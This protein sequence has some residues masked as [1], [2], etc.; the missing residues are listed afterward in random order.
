[1][2]VESSSAWILV[3]KKAIS[4]C[5]CTKRESLIWSFWISTQHE[6]LAVNNAV[7]HT[8]K[9]IVALRRCFAAD[10]YNHH[11]HD[12]LIFQREQRKKKQ[13]EP[14]PTELSA[15]ILFRILH[16][17][18]PLADSSQKPTPLPSQLSRERERE[19]FTLV[20]RGSCAGDESSSCCSS[21]SSGW[22]LRFLITEKPAKVA[23][24]KI[25]PCAMGI[26]GQGS[27]LCLPN[28]GR[29]GKGEPVS[30]S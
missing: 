27:S 23:D 1:M 26:S 17:Y 9:K 8:R 7:H 24:R 19:R 18:L 4:I 20:E 11:A 14:L 16:K 12:T 13:Q 29:L 22:V 21:L 3:Q 28:L 25:N 2:L 5:C 15:N 30:P 10:L 6:I